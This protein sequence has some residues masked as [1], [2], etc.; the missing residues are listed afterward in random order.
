M[1]KVSSM[2]CINCNKFYKLQDFFETDIENIKKKNKLLRCKECSL[3]YTY[4]YSN[5]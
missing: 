5:I 3:N 1:F 2:K 4:Y